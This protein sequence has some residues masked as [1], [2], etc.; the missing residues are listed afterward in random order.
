LN[1][2]GALAFLIEHD[3]F[4]KPVSTFPDHGPGSAAHRSARET[5]GVGFSLVPR[6]QCSLLMSFPGCG[7]AR[8]ASGAVL[9]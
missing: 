5:K 2:V 3:L 8:S 9:R 1:R 4:G 6:M 7:A